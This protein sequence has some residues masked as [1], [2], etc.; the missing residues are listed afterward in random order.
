MELKPT[1]K[2]TITD[3]VHHL[4]ILESKSFQNERT[5]INVGD[6][7][8]QIRNAELGDFNMDGYSDLFLTLEPS[9]SNDK[10]IFTLQIY[11]GE[12]SVPFAS[13]PAFTTVVKNSEPTLLDLYGHMNLDILA[14]PSTGE[15]AGVQVWKSAGSGSANPNLFDTP[16][17]VS[18]SLCTPSITH[19][20]A[21]V[22]INGDCKPDVF[23]T[24]N[25]NSYEMWSTSKNSYWELARKGELPKGAKFISFVDMDGDGTLDAVFPVCSSSS[26]DLRV[27]YNRQIPLC[28]LKLERDKVKC[29]PRTNLCAADDD[30]HIDFTNTQTIS[31]SSMVPSKK[32]ADVNRVRIG[33]YNLDGFSDIAVVSEGALYL[34]ESIPCDG[35][36]C[37]PETRKFSLIQKVLTSSNRVIDAVWFDLGENVCTGI[38]FVDP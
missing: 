14:I 3:R 9:K 27:A 30:F 34:L 20:N 36:Q 7:N 16:I 25:D 38:T 31:L 21:F 13:S 23:L 37:A 1:L 35:V 18:P 22:D 15:T 17:N 29:R 2:I 19:S 5:N 10:S 8:L 28:N 33:D 4:L 6:S 11:L 24:C 32:F 12:K 26:C